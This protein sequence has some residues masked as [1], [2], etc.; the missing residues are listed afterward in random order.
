VF[1]LFLWFIVVLL[2]DAYE[3]ARN[4][5]KTV[6]LYCDFS[7]AY[8]SQYCGRIQL[9]RHRIASSYFA[10]FSFFLREK[11]K[12]ILSTIFDNLANLQDITSQVFNLLL[13][14]AE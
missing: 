9:E 1:T 2:H 6:C 10:H 12:I 7:A 3:A 13:H 4:F 8:R 11:H 5:R 14:N